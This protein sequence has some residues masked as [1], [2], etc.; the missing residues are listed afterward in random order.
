ML[1]Q[2]TVVRPIHLA[3]VGPCTLISE[4]LNA[5]FDAQP[6]FEVTWTSVATADACRQLDKSPV[7][8][9]LLDASMK[10]GS[11][12]DLARRILDGPVSTK[13]VILSPH[14]CTLTLEWVLKFSLSGYL[15]YDDD[16]E[17][18]IIGIKRAF[19]G[20]HCWS[21]STEQHVK[22]NSR[23]GTY[24]LANESSTKRLTLR[25]K[26]IVI[27]LAHGAS[28]KVVARRLHLAEKSV[29]SHTYRIMKLLKIH[30]RVE[31]TH[32]AI[33]EGLIA[34]GLVNPEGLI[35]ENS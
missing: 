34:P 31:L 24:E 30:D 21:P 13:V 22:F 20:G 10:H 27:H 33:R 18:V 17:T 35:T 12:M 9:V 14:V 23:T 28:A 8:I 15:V 4:S 32:F 25:Q 2:A 29:N 3:I 5:F 11:P 1:C 26:E 7:D 6:E 19:A 16:P